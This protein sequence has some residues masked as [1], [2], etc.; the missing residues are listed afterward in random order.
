MSTATRDYGMV[1]GGEWTDSDARLEATSPASGESLGSV[2]DGTRED[3]GFRSPASRD[4]SPM[5]S[6][7]GPEPLP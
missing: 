3:D 4:R 2:P 7:L 6:V 5:R 1:I